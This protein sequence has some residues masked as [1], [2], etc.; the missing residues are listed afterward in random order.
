MSRS[1]LRA[2]YAEETARAYKDY[3]ITVRSE[4]ASHDD[5]QGAKDRLDHMADKWERLCWPEY[6]EQFEAERTKP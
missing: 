3:R 4:G 2:K 5:V 6:A 1:E